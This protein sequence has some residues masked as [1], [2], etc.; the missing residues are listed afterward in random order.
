MVPKHTVLHRHAGGVI[1][2]NDGGSGGSGGGGGS[3][4][5]GLVPA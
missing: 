1:R 2:P 3:T 4:L 5:D